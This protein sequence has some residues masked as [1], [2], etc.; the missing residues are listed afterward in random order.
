MIC[1]YCDGTL[2]ADGAAGPG[3]LPSAMVPFKVTREQAFESLQAHCWS[4]RYL[5]KGFEPHIERIRAVFVPFLLCDTQIEGEVSTL[6]TATYVYDSGRYSSHKTH[7][8]FARAVGSGEFKGI[9]LCLSSQAPDAL[10][11]NVAPF[12]T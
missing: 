6:V 1:P 11:R 12:D 7:R 3:M 9:P 2:L 4:K 5:A 10:M 8:Y